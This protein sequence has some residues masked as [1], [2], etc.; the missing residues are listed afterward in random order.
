[1]QLTGTRAFQASIVD[2]TFACR[3]CHELYHE[4]R[5]KLAE[6]RRESVE[7][8]GKVRE[9]PESTPAILRNRCYVCRRPRGVVGQLWELSSADSNAVP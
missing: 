6:R 1:M 8:K 9:M 7:G 2:V 5:L 3:R 4:D